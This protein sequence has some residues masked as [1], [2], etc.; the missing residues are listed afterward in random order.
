MK[1]P[2]VSF[3]ALPVGA[4]STGAAAAPQSLNKSSAQPEGLQAAAT[5]AGLPNFQL[6]L[7][8]ASGCT[9]PPVQMT[10]QFDHPEVLCVELSLLA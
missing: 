1:E 5:P 10:A 8:Q 2:D 6:A 3:T 9:L 7:K 4:A